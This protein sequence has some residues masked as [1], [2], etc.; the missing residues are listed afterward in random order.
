M[1]EG[2]CRDGRKG[3]GGGGM[4]VWLVVMEAACGWLNGWGVNKTRS[5]GKRVGQTTR[6]TGKREARRTMRG[7][8][9]GRDAG[10]GARAKK[11]QESRDEAK[12]APLSTRQNKIKQRTMIKLTQRKEMQR[13]TQQACKKKKIFGGS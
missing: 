9:G 12:H 11:G 5:L 8:L 4:R 13:N 1:A 2:L 7:R 3:G 10:S 6:R